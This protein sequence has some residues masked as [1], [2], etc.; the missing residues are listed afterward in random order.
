MPLLTVVALP[1]TFPPLFVEW[2]RKSLPPFF[3]RTSI[4]KGVGHEQPRKSGGA[5]R[6]QAMD[7]HADDA[8]LL[9][10]L[11]DGPIQ[12]RE[13]EV[14]HAF[15]MRVH[16]FRM[17]TKPVV[18]SDTERCTQVEKCGEVAGNSI[19][20]HP[21]ELINTEGSRVVA[22]WAPFAYGCRQPN[23]AAVLVRVQKLQAQYLP[24]K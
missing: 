12:V 6:Q 23:R 10:N 11:L 14:Q 20:K 5:Q 15:T 9:H 19:G 3:S 21:H 22:M 16:P 8:L 1:S 18:Q 13:R 2:H 24:N 7:A 17:V 4:A